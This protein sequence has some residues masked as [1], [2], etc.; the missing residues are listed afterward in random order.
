MVAPHAMYPK[1]T[2]VIPETRFEIFFL[3]TLSSQAAKYYKKSAI[4]IR[5]ARSGGNV[6]HK[7]PATSLALLATSDQ[8]GAYTFAGRA[9]IPITDGDSARERA[10]ALPTIVFFEARLI[11]IVTFV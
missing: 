5:M 8:A 7:D 2:T 1:V 9:M 3:I 11:G 10:R 4:I 6:S